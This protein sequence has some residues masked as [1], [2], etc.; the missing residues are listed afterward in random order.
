MGCF[1]PCEYLALSPISF[2][3]TRTG[4]DDNF[5]EKQSSLMRE[6]DELN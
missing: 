4:N 5:I 3:Y 6:M 1:V 2:I